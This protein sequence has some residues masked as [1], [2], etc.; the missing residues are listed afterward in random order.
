MGVPLGVARSQIVKHEGDPVGRPYVRGQGYRKWV[1]PGYCG[2]RLRDGGCSLGG[3]LSVEGGGV[4]SRI[5]VVL[6]GLP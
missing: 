4:P 6:P 3:F 5:L 2:F 1:P